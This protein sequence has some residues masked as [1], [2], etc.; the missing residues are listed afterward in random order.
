[1]VLE[2]EIDINGESKSTGFVFNQKGFFCK[3]NSGD[4]IVTKTFVTVWA[5]SLVELEDLAATYPQVRV[6]NILTI[7]KNQH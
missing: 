5:V 7:G 2:G 1:M 4:K 3:A 6:K